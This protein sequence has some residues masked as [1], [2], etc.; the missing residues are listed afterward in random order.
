MPVTKFEAR[1]GSGKKS[2]LAKKIALARPKLRGDERCKAQNVTNEAK[3][4]CAGFA[5]N[6]ETTKE[7]KH[8][9]MEQ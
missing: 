2:V 7:T 3:V 5:R 9:K 6:R 8:T 1:G 4:A